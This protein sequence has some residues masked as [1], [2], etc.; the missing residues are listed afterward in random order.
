MATAAWSEISLSN[1]LSGPVFRAWD[2]AINLLPDHPTM[3]D[4]WTVIDCSAGTVDATPPWS[5]TGWISDI[6]PTD[7]SWVALRCAQA[8]ADDTYREV[9]LG[10]VRGTHDLAGFGSKTGKGIY[11]CYSPIG[12]WN[13]TDH[14]FGA[15]LGDWRN[16]S[17]KALTGY[18]AAAVMKF[19]LS[20]GAADRPGGL[21]VL[22]RQGTGSHTYSFLVPEV[23]PPVGSAEDPRRSCLCYGQPSATGAGFLSTV[24]GGGIVPKTTLDG[25]DVSY[26]VKGTA[27]GTD[28]IDSALVAVDGIRVNNITTGLNIGLLV[29]PEGITGTNG[30]PDAGAGLAI[31]ENYAWPYDADRDGS[32][33]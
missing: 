6:S 13:T 8:N 9:F 4:T 10:Y 23:R 12:G 5:D 15:D 3:A 32:W 19:W 18:D 31:W 17:L 25:W 16:G 22:T 26:L 21:G 11:C 2:A 14:L 1:G 33:V 27:Y 20:S 29:A 24:G 7:P 28:G 30:E